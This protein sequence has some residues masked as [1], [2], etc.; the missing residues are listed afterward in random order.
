MK[1]ALFLAAMAFL[2][3]NVVNAQ[4]EDKK[5]IDEQK[6]EKEKA[7]LSTAKTTINLNDAKK[8]AVGQKEVTA[9]K[10]PVTYRGEGTAVNQTLPQEKKPVNQNQRQRPYVVKPG[11]ANNSAAANIDRN[12]GAERPRAARTVKT[13][14]STRTKE[15]A[16]NALKPKAPSDPRA[17]NEKA[18][19]VKTDK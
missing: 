4:G 3:V 7:Q 18:E 5:S 2:A 6:E 10:A 1:K 12:A 19:Q 11:S 15:V 13:T 14:L 17:K 8:T 16:P 9:E